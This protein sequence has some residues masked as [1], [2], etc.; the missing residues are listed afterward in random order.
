MLVK[1][2]RYNNTIQLWDMIVMFG[3]RCACTLPLTSFNEHN[4]NTQTFSV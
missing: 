1:A 4:S 2:L 3:L